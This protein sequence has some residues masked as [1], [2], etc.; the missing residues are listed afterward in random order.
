VQIRAALISH[1]F[2]WNVPVAL[3]D[4]TGAIYKFAGISLPGIREI[5]LP[6]SVDLDPSNQWICMEPG[7]AVVYDLKNDA[8]TRA[9]LADR[10]SKEMAYLDPIK[11]LNAV[12]SI[13]AIY[14]M[15][16][17]QVAAIKT[18]S[19]KSNVSLLGKLNSLLKN[20]LS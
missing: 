8:E 11:R 15:D 17:R 7:K 10:A 5:A 2:P 20:E 18:G 4:E 1:D 14:G 19:A 16:L 12:Q 6:E 3:I 9:S 13:L